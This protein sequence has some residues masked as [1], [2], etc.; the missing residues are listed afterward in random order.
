MGSDGVIFETGMNQLKLGTNSLGF[1]NGMK[2]K[3]TDKRNR[4]M[5]KESDRHDEDRRDFGVEGRMVIT[6][7]N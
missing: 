4:E 6:E 7:Q 2:V 5:K 3:K 1:E